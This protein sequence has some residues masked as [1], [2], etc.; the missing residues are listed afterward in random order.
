MCA[1]GIHR[2]ISRTQ[3]SPFPRAENRSSASPR[4]V[5]RGVPG[6]WPLALGQSASAGA[7][8]RSPRGRRIDWDRLFSRA[9]T[10]LLLSRPRPGAKVS[11]GLG[12]AAVGG[13]GRTEPSHGCLPRSLPRALARPLPPSPPFPGPGSGLGP[14][15]VR[16]S[17]GRMSGS[18][19]PSALALSLLLVSGSLLPGPGAAQNGKRGAGGGPGGGWGKLAAGE[20]RSGP[21]EVVEPG[22]GGRQL[23]SG[24][25]RARDE[26]MPVGSSKRRWCENRRCLSERW[27]R[28]IRAWGVVDLEA[29][30]LG[31]CRSESGRGPQGSRREELA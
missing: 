12:A 10:P 8:T 2:G 25:L 6:T 7:G 5:A 30:R 9:L 26:Q 18:S 3:T 13:R 24:G 16:S 15:A 31:A 20:G 1:P 14:F 27:G 22:E 19:L 21:E 29:P 28:P 4:H 23:E 11:R 17:A